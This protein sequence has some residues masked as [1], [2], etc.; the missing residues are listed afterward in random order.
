MFEGALNGVFEDF[1]KLGRCGRHWYSEMAW[2]CLVMA[3]ECCVPESP[4]MMVRTTMEKSNV[5]PRREQTH[6]MIAPPI[7]AGGCRGVM[8]MGSIVSLAMMG[9][10]MEPHKTRY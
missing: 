5:R 4:S 10:S 8:D 9:G 7:S 3:S 6:C 1:G 2:Y